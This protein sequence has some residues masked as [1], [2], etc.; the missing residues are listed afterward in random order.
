MLVNGDEFGM[1][2]VLECLRIVENIRNILPPHTHTQE[3]K[4]KE[5]NK[6]EIF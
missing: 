5:E 3:R 1:I 4:E 6:K 2:P